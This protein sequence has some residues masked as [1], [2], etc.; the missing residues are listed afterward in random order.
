MELLQ[1]GE[2]IPDV[3][4]LGQNAAMIWGAPRVRWT[5]GQRR[6]ARHFGGKKAGAGRF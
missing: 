4:G 6:P 3:L 1:I 2:S 5:L